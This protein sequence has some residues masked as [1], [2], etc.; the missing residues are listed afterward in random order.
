MALLK[1]EG[2]DLDMK[3][4]TLEERTNKLENVVSEISKEVRTVLSDV[5]GTITELDNPMN[6]LKGLG[7]DEVMLSMAE[8]IT[9]SKLKEFMEKRLEALTK[10]VVEGKLRE[11]V[12]QLIKKF[13]DEQIGAIIEGKIKELREKGI[14]NVPI[15]PNE[16]KKALD[17]K[18][19]EVI[20]LDDIKTALREELL[21][22]IKPELEGH[23][24]AEIE[25]LRQSLPETLS[26]STNTAPALEQG[27]PKGACTPAGAKTVA[28]IVGLTACAGALM[29]LSGRRGS[30]R[31]IDDYYK[32]GLIPDEARSALLR[33]ISIITTKDLP[34]EREI[35]IDDQIMIT[36][37]FDKLTDGGSDTDFLITLML[38]NR[39][40][41]YPFEA[42]LG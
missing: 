11:L 37:L 30:E 26:N 23:L 25:A 36:Y 41:H 32:R 22:M 34:D 20:K 40:S 2:E 1:E 18:L 9:E 4:V 6:F 8:N 17:E 31:V 27:L 10:T 42:R 13:V 21:K 7:I 38:L 35:G 16:L 12:D 28:G 24:K 33:L 14:L 3:V 39:A 15:D 5:R 29:R 19:S